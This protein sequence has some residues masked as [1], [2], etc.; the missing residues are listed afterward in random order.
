MAL[1]SL[2]RVWSAQRPTS[3]RP[4]LVEPCTHI[5][6]GGRSGRVA[7]SRRF[8]AHQAKCCAAGA[9]VPGVQ[10]SPIPSAKAEN[11]SVLGVLVA[12]FAPNAAP[13]PT[14]ITFTSRYCRLRRDR[15][16]PLAGTLALDGGV[17]HL[18]HSLS[19]R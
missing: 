15:D 3:P 11:S 19:S 5:S 10:C 6:Q 7:A 2:N 9:G 4:T 18:H 12:R 13:N 16:A 14:K 17:G 1:S 8:W